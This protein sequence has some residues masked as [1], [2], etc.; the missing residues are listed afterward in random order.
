MT[1]IPGAISYTWTVVTGSTIVS[2]LNTNSITVNWGSIN[3][4]I[5]VKVNSAC[6]VSSP[7]TLGVAFTCK[8]GS[9]NELSNTIS[10]YPV[11]TDRYTSID[12]L[13]ETDGLQT[14]IYVYNL[15]G[16]KVLFETAILQSGENKITIDCKNLDNGTYIMKV[17]NKEI[18]KQGRILIEK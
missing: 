15:L 10:P 14:E 12:L 4:T 11:P 17:H 5:S 13:S 16:E 9:N 18:N 3:G 7:G 6:G 8:E 2:G 1:P